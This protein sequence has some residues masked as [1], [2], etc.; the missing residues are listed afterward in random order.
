MNYMKGVASAHRSVQLEVDS[1]FLEVQARDTDVGFQPGTLLFFVGHEFFPIPQVLDWA[2]QGQRWHVWFE[3]S[4]R[5]NILITT[6]LYCMRR[7]DVPL[8]AA[9]LVLNL[10]SK[11]VKAVKQPITECLYETM[12]LGPLDP[13]CKDRI[14]KEWNA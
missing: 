2:L 1:G 8:Q 13:W 5:S 11:N 10:D 4:L 7:G 6:M 9:R 12:G 14:P 3:L